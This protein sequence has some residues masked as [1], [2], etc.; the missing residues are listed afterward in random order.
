[1]EIVAIVILFLL[2]IG[3][4]IFMTKAFVQSKACQKE[5]KNAQ[6]L[7]QVMFEMIASNKTVEQ[8][9]EELNQTLLSTYHMTYSSIVLFDGYKNHVKVS[10]VEKMYQECIEE[11]HT[12]NVFRK[13]ITSN[14]IKYLT[15]EDGGTLLYKSAIERKVKSALLFPIYDKDIYFGYVLLEDTQKQYFDF[16]PKEEMETLKK[17]I[18]LFLENIHYQSTIEEAETIDKQTGFYNNIYLYSNARK[19]LTRYDNSALILVFLEGL[20]QINENY[21]R[22]IANTLL[23]KLAN[24]SKKILPKETMFIRYSGQRF[25]MVLPNYTAEKVHPFIERLLF[26]YKN[27]YEVYEEHKVKLDTKIVIHTFKKQNNIEEEIQKMS[28]YFDKIRDLNVI[29]II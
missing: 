7:L 27:E 15:I 8:K 29:K 16:M 4:V 5:T 25:L 28:N 9:L 24:I 3:I 14:T 19:E 2:V 13:N 6:H 23:I 17:N 22:N 21:N 1:M 26:G 18:G 10:N 11:I 12:E 20:P